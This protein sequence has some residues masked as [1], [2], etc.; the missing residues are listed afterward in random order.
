VLGSAA[1]TASAR[2]RDLLFW[3]GR[4]EVFNW[5]APRIFA[6]ID[7]WLYPRVHGVVVS[8]GPAVLP[9]LML[10]TWGRH[11]GRSR[12]VPLLYLQ[13]QNDLLVVASNW[14]RSKHPAWSSNLL[15]NP[16]A[17]VQIGETTS[18]AAARLIPPAEK[19]ML[20][21]E[22]C[23]FCP[24]WQSYADRSGRDLRVFSLSLSS[25]SRVAVKR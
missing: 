21:P 15:A 17:L 5:L 11:S 25:P 8:T 13:R 14:G 7:T 10:T 4:R 1:T 24:V 16:S 22:L 12:A 3:L 23:R 6:P 9:L 2:Y 18:A 20:W 19:A